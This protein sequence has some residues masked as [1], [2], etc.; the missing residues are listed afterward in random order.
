MN[1]YLTLKGEEFLSDMRRYGHTTS[2][3]RDDDIYSTDV[4]KAIRD[5]G[6]ADVS[7]R[8]GKRFD[9]YTLRLKD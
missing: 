1:E 3:V 9:V 7:F 6:L 8:K 2:I 4:V 5:A